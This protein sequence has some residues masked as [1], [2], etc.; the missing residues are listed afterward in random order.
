MEGFAGTR[1]ERQWLAALQR[2][3]DALTKLAEKEEPPKE[4][5]GILAHEHEIDML[6]Q[7]VASLTSSV[8]RIANLVQGLAGTPAEMEMLAVA[9][10]RI[11]E[12]T[13]KLE[14]IGG[15]RV[16]WREKE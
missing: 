7:Q 4:F 5:R 2:I 14:L 15:N 13:D 16:R 1:A 8:E 6:Q 9:I 3:G 10:D 12:T 11:K